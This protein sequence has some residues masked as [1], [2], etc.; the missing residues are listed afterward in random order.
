MKA[1]ITQYR[2]ALSLTPASSEFA[3]NLGNAL[4]ASGDLKGSIDAY[5]NAVTLAPASPEA[6]TNLGDALRQA[7]QLK[8]A[9]SALNEA[10][11]IAPDFVTA[12]YQLAVLMV[13]EARYDDALEEVDASLAISP[14]APDVLALRVVLLEALGKSDDARQLFDVER[15]LLAEVLEPPSGF[16]TIR[17]FN[18][19]LEKHVL[20]RSRLTPDP[21]GASTRGGRHSDDLFAGVGAVRDGLRQIV[22]GT[23]SNY[24]AK[25][26]SNGDHPFLQHRPRD[27]RLVAQANV[28]DRDGYLIAHV[29]PQAWLS[30]AYY[31]RLPSEIRDGDPANAGWLRFGGAVEGIRLDAAR[32]AFHYVK[33]VEGM[34]VLFPSFFVHGTVPLSAKRHRLSLG[35]DVVAG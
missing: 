11:R 13:E 20:E 15:F 25:L 9:Q 7:K 22:Q 6:H 35:V 21:F 24:V 34:L 14:Y 16:D 30:G 5:R 23:V 33:P 18:R 1:A 8:D 31:V 2:R 32:S 26:T 27:V 12:R 29:H 17:R 3:N 28:L 19:E 10:L 4:Q